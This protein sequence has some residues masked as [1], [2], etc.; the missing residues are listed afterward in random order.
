M[1]SP[2]IWRTRSLLF[3]WKLSKNLTGMGDITS[4]YAITS[5]GFEFTD[6]LSASKNSLQPG[7]GI[8]MEIIVCCI[9]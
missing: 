1:E 9:S 7:G 2:L 4:S 8:V 5:I 3:V 6:A